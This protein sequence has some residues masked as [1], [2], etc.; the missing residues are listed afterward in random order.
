MKNISQDRRSC[1]YWLTGLPSAGKTT[2]ARCIHKM[3]C[4]QSVSSFVLDG[5]DL[6]QGLNSDLG[7]TPADRSDPAKI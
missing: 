4:N 1:C 6:R 2:L 7:Y 3:F 5:D